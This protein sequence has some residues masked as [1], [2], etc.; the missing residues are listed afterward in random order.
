LKAPGIARLLGV[1]VEREEERRRR[2]RAPAEEEEEEGMS[3]RREGWR[4]G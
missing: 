4:E 3:C 1:G 2:R